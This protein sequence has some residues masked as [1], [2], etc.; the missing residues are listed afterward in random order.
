MKKFLIIALF[1]CSFSFA[2]EITWKDKWAGKDKF[3]HATI[4]IAI[5]TVTGA[6][7][8]DKTTAFA[9]AMLPGIAKEI[10]DYKHSNKHSA[11]FKDLAADAV[12]AAVGVYVGNCVI[13]KQSI[14]C[15]WQF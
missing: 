4:E 1:A 3:Q 15:A 6:Y 14:T 10:Y 12:G 7:F 5:G 8:E 9:V 11:S 2:D 13:R